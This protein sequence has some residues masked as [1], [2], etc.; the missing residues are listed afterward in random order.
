MP[1]KSKFQ[2]KFKCK[3]TETWGWHI[4]FSF[5]VS[6]KDAFDKREIYLLICLGKR[7]LVIGMINEYIEED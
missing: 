4:G 5:C 2:Y 6:P 3:F 7:D 1:D